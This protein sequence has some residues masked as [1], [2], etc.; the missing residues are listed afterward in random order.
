MRTFWEHWA[1]LESAKSRSFG[2][3]NGTHQTTPNVPDS[4][5]DAPSIAV[6]N[7]VPQQREG[8]D[9]TCHTSASDCISYASSYFGAKWIFSR[10]SK[11]TDVLFLL[12][13]PGR[14]SPVRRDRRCNRS[15]SSTSGSEES[16]TWSDSKGSARNRWGGRAVMGAG[17]VGSRAGGGP[18]SLES[19]LALYTSVSDSVSRA[20]R[21]LIPQQSALQGKVP[22]EE[23]GGTRQTSGTREAVGKKAGGT[24]ASAVKKFAAPLGEPVCRWSVS[25]TRPSIMETEL[26]GWHQT[27][28]PPSLGS[29]PGPGQ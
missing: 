29:K 6:C 16:G 25:S 8:G 27:Q 20:F 7:A 15:R 2:T 24:Q 3:A 17:G 4:T 23:G 21:R 14:R 28:R 18:S 11:C 26:M 19:A 12:S 1:R 5:C 22:A 10:E 13:A 9:N